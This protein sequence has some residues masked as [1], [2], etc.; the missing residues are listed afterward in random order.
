MLR[1][2]ALRGPRCPQPDRRG[3]CLAGLGG[4]RP[5]RRPLPRNHAR[6]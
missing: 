6:L 5:D 1:P 2:P 3:A 4:K